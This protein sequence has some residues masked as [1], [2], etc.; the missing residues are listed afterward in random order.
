MVGSFYSELS[1]STLRSS[2]ID[3]PLP[4]RRSGSNLSSGETRWF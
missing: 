1:L 2:S 4:L 3:L